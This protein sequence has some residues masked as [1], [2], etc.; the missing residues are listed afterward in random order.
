MMVHCNRCGCDRR[1]HVVNNVARCGHCGTTD[2]T[3]LTDLRYHP[4]DPPEVRRLLDAL[5]PDDEVR[6][7]AWME[8][9]PTTGDVPD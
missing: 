5:E 7:P 3:A 2:V 6:Y 4:A 8:R 1:V 9:D